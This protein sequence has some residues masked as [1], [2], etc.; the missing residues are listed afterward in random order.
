MLQMEKIYFY[1]A[2]TSDGSFLKDEVS[3]I[4][5]KKRKINEIF[6]LKEK[7]NQNQIQYLNRFKT[8]EKKFNS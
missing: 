6:L 8:L 4:E 5:N 1:V 3:I 2:L 7:L